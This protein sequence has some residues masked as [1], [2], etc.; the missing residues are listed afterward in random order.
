MALCR[1]AALGGHVDRCARCGHEE[2]PSYNSC[3]NRHCPSCQGFAARV[4]VATRVE[5]ILP[6]THFHV[7]FTL[8]AP[9][10][11]LFGLDAAGMYDR[12]FAAAATTLRVLAEKRLGVQ[13][14]VTA[15]LH[16]WNQDLGYHPHIHAIVTGGGLD[17]AGRWK[18]T[19]EGYL[20]P[21]PWLAAFFRGAM[22]RALRE[23]YADQTL[24]VP[25]EWEQPG[26]FHAAMQR[27]YQERWVVY[28]KRPFGGTEAIFE[29]LGR[30]THRV[31]ISD[32]RLVEVTDDD[33]T[34]RRRNR[35][36][37]TVT[38]AEFVRRLAR[39]ILPDGFRKIRHY[40]LYASSNV[41]T[42]LETARAQLPPPPPPSP[43][44]A[45]NAGIEDIV[46]VVRCIDGV[47]VR[48]CPGCH[49]WAMHRRIVAAQK[50]P[51]QPGRTDTA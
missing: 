18:A 13:L 27:L 39:H 15:V 14:G 3:R 36:D 32:H 34:F 23:A 46:P 11:R 16:T 49:E 5:R 9:L 38:P 20:L 33:V 28:A 45:E 24:P 40:G 35:P 4:W 22:L 26:P 48:R 6:V 29:Y 8:P 50:Q 12:L 19:P 7:V 21:Q 10:R 25:P 44:P 17:A 47:E 42:R 30:Y 51:P 41:R 43:A 2:P 1:T 31:G 37:T